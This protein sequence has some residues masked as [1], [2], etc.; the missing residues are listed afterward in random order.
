MLTR[1]ALAGRKLLFTKRLVKLR[2]LQNRRANC[3]PRVLGNLGRGLSR[4]LACAR[5]RLR[6]RRKVEFLARSVSED[7]KALIKAIRDGGAGAGIALNPETSLGAIDDVIG[8]IDLLLIMSVHPGFG[9][10]DF[11]PEVLDKVRD[12]R[13]QHPDLMI[14]MDGDIDDQ[15]VGSCIE[16][17]ANNFVSGSNIFE[18]EDRAKTIASLRG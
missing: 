10:Q 3:Q 2:S 7:R 13:G 14:Q 15:S 6:A 17:G 5:I 8:D 11:L 16:A 12:A 18:S 4:G 9:G 1:D